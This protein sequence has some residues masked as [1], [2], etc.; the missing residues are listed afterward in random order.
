MVVAREGSVLYRVKLDDGQVI[1]RQ[2]EQLRH[3]QDTGDLRR[4]SENATTETEL[5]PTAR[6]D[7]LL[8]AVEHSDLSFRP[9]APTK[10][11]ESKPLLESQEEPLNSVSIKS[12]FIESQSTE[13]QTTKSQ[14]MQECSVLGYWLCAC[15]Y[16][17][18]T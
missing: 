1:Q 12:Q 16:C 7:S 8:D 14:P 6:G 15:L 13:S 9:S 2:G 10:T 5:N 17:I 4:V 11:A 18:I 3:R